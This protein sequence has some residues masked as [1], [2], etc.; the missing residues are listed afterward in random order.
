MEDKGLLY[1][2]IIAKGLIAE[3]ENADLFNRAKDVVF[4]E[5]RNHLRGGVKEKDVLEETVRSILKSYFRKEISR[6]PVIVPVIL[7]V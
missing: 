7:E 1:P 4:K 3:Q 5:V 2:E 6:L